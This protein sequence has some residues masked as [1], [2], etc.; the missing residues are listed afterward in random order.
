[1]NCNFV[2]SPPVSLGALWMLPSTEADLEG[3][4][5]HKITTTPIGFLLNQISS[6][7]LVL[8]HKGIESLFDLDQAQY[9][10]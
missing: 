10:A 8:A 9:S 6:V 3:D 1:M 7:Q 5:K 2:Q 4:Q